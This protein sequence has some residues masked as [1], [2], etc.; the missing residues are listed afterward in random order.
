MEEIF[1][2]ANEI[3][4]ESQEIGIIYGEGVKYYG[5]ICGA[6]LEDLTDSVNLE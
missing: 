3:H 6:I 5:Q 2:W 4:F 1:E